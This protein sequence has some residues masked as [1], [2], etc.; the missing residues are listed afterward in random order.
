MCLLCVIILDLAA[1]DILTVIEPSR[2]GLGCNLLSLVV[3][4]V[5]T[6]LIAL[7]VW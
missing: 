4:I 2:L 7:K 1:T 3:N 5:A 6:L